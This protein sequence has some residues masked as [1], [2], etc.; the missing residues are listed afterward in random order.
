MKVTALDLYMRC[1]EPLI[2]FAEPA[3]LPDNTIKLYI[4]S[5]GY[6]NKYTYTYHLSNDVYRV[7]SSFDIDI[8]KIIR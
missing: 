2:P 1:I 6:V 4:Q 3:T 8:T 5:G 7:Y